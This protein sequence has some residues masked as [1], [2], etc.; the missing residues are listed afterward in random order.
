M[1]LR[2]IVVIRAEDS[3]RC[4]AAI[5]SVM[6]A[7]LDNIFGGSG[8]ALKPLDLNHGYSWMKTSGYLDPY[9]LRH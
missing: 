1:R 5:T 7:T 2:V 3:L 4:A 8:P 9:Q 6:A